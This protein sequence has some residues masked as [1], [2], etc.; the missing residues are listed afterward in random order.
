MSVKL[1]DLQT[2]IAALTI[3]GVKRIHTATSTPK[4]VYGRDLPILM[5]DPARPMQSGRSD[6][7]TVGR[8]PAL[9]MWQRERTL[10]YVCLVAEVGAGRKPGD[11]AVELSNVLEAVDNALCDFATDGV[12][13]VGPVVIAD[14]GVMQDAV[15][16]AVNPQ[17]ARQFIGFTVQVTVT[18]SY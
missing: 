12:H 11:Y 15:S 5:P 2:A 7:R 9:A 14:V 3:A 17:Q 13:N 4:E 10:N 1:A 8:V 6:R 16:A 18:M